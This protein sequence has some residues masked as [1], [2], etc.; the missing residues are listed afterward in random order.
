MLEPERSALLFM[1]VGMKSEVF[2]G[3]PVI[4]FWLDCVISKFVDSLIASISPYPYGIVTDVIS[5]LSFLENI[6]S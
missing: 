4:G 3:E 6:D 2:S 5:D 1:S